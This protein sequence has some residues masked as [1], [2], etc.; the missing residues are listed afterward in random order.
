MICSICLEDN[1]NK[2]TKLKCGHCYHSECIEKWFVENDTCPYCREPQNP[3]VIFHDDCKP[4]IITEY[5][6]SR[7][8]SVM[9]S[10]SGPCKIL[11]DP[12]GL[13]SID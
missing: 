8:I 2:E 10:L 3:T 6:V 5:F 7:L 13:L 9:M 12:E 4:G 1:I 11:V